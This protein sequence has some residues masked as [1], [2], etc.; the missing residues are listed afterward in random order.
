[1]YDSLILTEHTISTTSGGKWLFPHILLEA[2]GS[3]PIAIF[4]SD[5]INKQNERGNIM[6]TTQQS[7]IEIALQQGI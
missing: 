3:S 4:C 1:M 6:D 5:P 7:I 2:N